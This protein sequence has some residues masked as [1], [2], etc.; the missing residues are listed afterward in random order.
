MIVRRATEIQDP[1][2]RTDAD[3][4]SPLVN[5]TRTEPVS[6]RDAVEAVAAT[7]RMAPQ[8]SDRMVRTRFFIGILS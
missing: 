5:T 3:D 2:T 7:P 1:A 6:A 8:I 4:K